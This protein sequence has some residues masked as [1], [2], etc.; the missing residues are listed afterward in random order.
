MSYITS[1]VAVAVKICLVAA[2]G[3]A[4]AGDAI[5]LFTIKGFR[6]TAIS[7]RAQFWRPRSKRTGL[8]I[9]RNSPHSSTGA[10]CPTNQSQ[11]HQS[12][13]QTAH[14]EEAI[15]GRE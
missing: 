10:P 1:L 5:T 12:F 13:L 6:A 4:Y 11:S 15:H 7:R 2:T 14:V 9:Q 3:C 8:S